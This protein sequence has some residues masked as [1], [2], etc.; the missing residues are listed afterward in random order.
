MF[1]SIL[2]VICSLIHLYVFWRISSVPF[3]KRHIPLKYLILTCLILWALLFSGLFL[4]HDG[5]GIFAYALELFAMTWMAVLFLVFI[6][7]FVSDILT[8][9]GF[10]FPNLS[11]SIRGYALIAGALLSITAFFQGYRSPVIKSYEVNLTDLPEEL[12]GT[13]IVALSDLHVGSQLGYQWLSS[14]VDQVNN[15]RPDI[16]VLLGDIVE[17]HGNDNEEAFAT[18]LSRLS[19]PMGVWAVLGNHENFTRGD[20][21]SSSLFEKAGIPVLRGNWKELKAGL[22]IAGIDPSRRRMDGPER[23]TDSIAP[24]L[25][26]RPDGATILLSHFPLGSEE[27]AGYGVDLMLCGHTHGGQIWPFSYIVRASYP[28]LAG[29]YEVSEMPV[30]VSRG[31]GTWGPRMRLWKPGE[32]LRIT[33]RSRNAQNQQAYN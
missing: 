19:A 1:G 13:V 2:I 20:G 7:L 5:N 15:Q 3:I 32:I 4:G 9:F 33:L 29:K 18:A 6:S 23:E 25:A 26:G 30:I 28:L 14:R 21:N 24:A 31:A 27:A 16:I 10:L 11:V 8:G 12:D 22:I 17:G